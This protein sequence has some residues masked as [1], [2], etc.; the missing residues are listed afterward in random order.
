MCAVTPAARGAALLDRF[1][2]KWWELVDPATLD[3]ADIEKCVLAQVFRGTYGRGL[4][5]LQERL[6]SAGEETLA[7]RVLSLPVEFGFIQTMGNAPA[8]SREWR[9]LVQ[10][11]KT[12]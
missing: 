2:E 3:I 4:L 8:L 10:A 5:M 7:E 1:V 12:S 6:R 9:Q 11:R